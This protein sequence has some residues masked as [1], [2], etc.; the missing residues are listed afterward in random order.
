MSRPRIIFGAHKLALSRIPLL[1]NS[2]VLRGVV[3]ASSE[4][5]RCVGWQRVTDVSGTIA[6]PE[7]SLN[8]CQTTPHTF[9]YR[10]AI[11]YHF[12]STLFTNFNH[13]T[14]KTSVT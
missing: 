13:V 10:H 2:R 1:R 8:S 3:E 9:Q 5:L 4:I 12:S 7:S 14:V 11:F 6:S